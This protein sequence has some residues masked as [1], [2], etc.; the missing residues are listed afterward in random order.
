MPATTFLANKL[1]E[2]QVGKTAYTM[3]TVFVGLSSTTP[4]LAGTGITEPSGGSY[5]RVATSGATWATAASGSIS[6]AA[7]I[8]FPTATADWAAAANLTYGVLYDASTAGNVLGYG[9]LT[10]AK[11]VLNGDTASIAIGGLTITIS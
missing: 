7:A 11:N 3:P 2:H 5:A 9:V 10:V 1:L 8:T 4:A 6:N